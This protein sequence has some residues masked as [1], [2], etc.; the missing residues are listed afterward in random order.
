MSE[1][2]ELLA[3]VNAELRRRITG[4]APEEFSE[5]GQR[6]RLMSMAEL[7]ALRKDLMAEVGAQGGSSFR[8]MQF[9]PQLG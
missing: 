6:F 7:Q 8:L 9:D 2:A 1:S 3:L 5:G 4:G